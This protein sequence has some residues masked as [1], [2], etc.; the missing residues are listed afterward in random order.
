[1]DCKATLWRRVDGNWCKPGMI[2]VFLFITTIFSSCYVVNELAN[3]NKQTVTLLQNILQKIDTIQKSNNVLQ[4]EYVVTAGGTNIKVY[5]DSIRYRTHRYLTELNFLTQKKIHEFDVTSAGERTKLIRREAENNLLQLQVAEE[6]LATVY[7]LSHVPAG[8]QTGAV[9]KE[10]LQKIDNINTATD[11]KLK[12][13]TLDGN[14][15]VI[16]KNYTDTIKNKTLQHIRED[17][18]IS[19]MPGKH[20]NLND[21]TTRV[22]KLAAEAQDNLD[23]IKIV[24]ELLKTN[25]FTLVQS[26]NLFGPGKFEFS[27]D[28]M[29]LVEESFSPPVNDIINFLQKFPGKQL[30]VCIVALGYSDAGNIN[31][32]SVLG[33]I[34]LD[35]MHVQIAGKDLLNKELSRLRAKSV[36]GFFDTKFK[37]AGTA[38][39]QYQ[40]LPQGRG[41]E[42]PDPAIKDY[43]TNDTRRRVVKVYWTVVPVTK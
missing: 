20:K 9:L 28:K 4:Q 8:S 43:T 29:P 2:P 10:T 21:I 15:A 1:M 23:N 39:T 35:S 3:E 25:T 38:T 34:L 22:K 14:S 13:N 6:L 31:T 40:Y 26:G 24:D 7:A 16:I 5:T 36:V 11:A 33:K 19:N 42:I 12:D 30:T 17:S 18:I 27:Q 41:E 32:A 37:N